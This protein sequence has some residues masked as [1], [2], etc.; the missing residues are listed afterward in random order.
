MPQFNKLIGAA[1]VEQESV[2]AEIVEPDPDN[3]PFEAGDTPKS[4]SIPDGF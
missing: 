4:S 1:K 2:S 3:I